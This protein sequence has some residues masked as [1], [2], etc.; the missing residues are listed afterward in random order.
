MLCIMW[1]QGKPSE[2]SKC[3]PNL[4]TIQGSK[5]ENTST[6]KKKK[7]CC[8]WERWLTSYRLTVLV[9]ILFER[10]ISFLQISFFHSYLR[11]ASCAVWGE[12][13]V[14]VCCYFVTFVFSSYFALQICVNLTR[15][16]SLISRKK[17][18][19]VC[20]FSSEAAI[21]WCSSI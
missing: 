14:R 21:C 18:H 16:T 11:K 19:E 8:R 6:K 12:T 15:D 20:T 3:I 1:F 10:T 2:N 4:Q 7:E 9:Y 13:W 17:N 5:K